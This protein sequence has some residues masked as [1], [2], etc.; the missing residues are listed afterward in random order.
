MSL[1]KMIWPDFLK[2]KPVYQAKLEVKPKEPVIYNLPAGV[3]AKHS[4]RAKRLALRLDT[5]ARTFY[6]VIPKRTSKKRAETFAW[7]HA[8]WMKERLDE[9]PEKI[10]FT[11]GLEFSFMGQNM[12]VEVDQSPD[13]KR[14]I[15]QIHDGVMHVRTNKD[16]A[17]SRIVRFLKTQA[18]ERLE[19]L[20]RAKASAHGLKIQKVTIRDTKT[21]WGSCS[22][23][24]NLSFSW[25]LIFAP[26]E[27]ID[28]VVAHEVA[29]LVHLDH[30]PKFWKV[31]EKLSEDYKTGKSWMRQHAHELMRY[32]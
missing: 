12:R 30:S 5:K 29:H 6:L 9:L 24:G 27:S 2:K 25:R 20:A 13:Y 15:I 8:D 23:D 22:V 3:E 11:D 14:T 1:N 28:Y 10:E 32:Q 18:K 16:S 4:A 19:A 31:C 26:Y 17:H 21:R 7:Q